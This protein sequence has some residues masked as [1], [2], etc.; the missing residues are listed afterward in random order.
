MDVGLESTYKFQMDLRILFARCKLIATREERTQFTSTKGSHFS[1]FLV[2]KREKNDAITIS[3][4]CEREFKTSLFPIFYSRIFSKISL[5]HF[6]EVILQQISVLFSIF[7]NFRIHAQKFLFSFLRLFFFS[8]L[9]LYS[10]F[11]RLRKF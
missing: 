3:I 9:I 6:F 7:S 4:D 8:V 2:L 1:P 5:S 11:F 10:F